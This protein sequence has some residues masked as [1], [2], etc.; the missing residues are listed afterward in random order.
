MTDGRERGEKNEGR[1]RGTKTLAL[2]EKGAGDM[3]HLTSPD[4]H[5]MRSDQMGDGVSR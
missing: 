2:K 1:I 4:N 5:G 3:A